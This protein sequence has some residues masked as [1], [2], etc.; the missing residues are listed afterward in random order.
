MKY[1][2]KVQLIESINTNNTF[3]TDE[4]LMHDFYNTSDST[5]NNF[6][7]GIVAKSVGK[8]S[9]KLY[10]G[11]TIINLTPHHV[12]IYIDKDEIITIKTKGLHK[13]VRCLSLTKCIGKIANIDLTR[14]ELGEVYNLP[15]EKKDVYYI[16]S[17]MVFDIIKDRKDLLVPNDVVRNNEGD[18][19]GCRNLGIHI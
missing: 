3:T 7:L 6:D 9:Y 5:F 19:I 4:L 2:S 8:D 1:Y 11:T 10:P 14:T 17:R 15:N 16:V 13:A 18:V 12:N